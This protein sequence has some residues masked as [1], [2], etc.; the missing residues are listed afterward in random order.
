LR[1]ALREDL[2]SG[3]PSSGPSS[4]SAPGSSGAAPDPA[5]SG[6]SSGSAPGSSGDHVALGLEADLMT[7]NPLDPANLVMTAPRLLLGVS[8]RVR[9]GPVTV[10]VSVHN[11]LGSTVQDLAGFP[12]PGLSAFAS[13][14][15]TP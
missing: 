15:Y 10:V 6:P 4:G 12:L 3:P 2:A 14:R 9:R 7:A 13:L 8:G 1:A 5:P 11:L